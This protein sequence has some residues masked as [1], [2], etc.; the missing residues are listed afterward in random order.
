MK[1]ITL[2]ACIFLVS[3]HNHHH[4]DNRISASDTTFTSQRIAKTATILLND[5]VEKV[6]PL[7]G[8]FEERKWSEGWNP[9]LIYPQKEIIE[10]GTTFRTPGHGH[11]ET[12]FIWTVSKYDPARFLIQYLV[13]SSNR[14]WTI[15]IKCN[16][17]SGHSSSAEI[18]YS[19]TG[20]NA[21]GN[22]INEHF[23]QII[24]RHDLSDWAE[25]INHYLKTQEK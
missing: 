6:F 11:G 5:R 19:F 8:A 15:T 2:F 22:E 21:L 17:V 7:F 12:G 14:I 13:Y 4:M 23:L 24:Y 3:W 1:A 16:P 18:T 20:L 10:E 9:T 25:D